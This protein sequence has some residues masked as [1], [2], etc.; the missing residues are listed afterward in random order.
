MPDWVAKANIAHFKKL[1]EAEKDPRKR[2]MIERELAEEEAKLVAIE[3][4]QSK[5]KA[6]KDQSERKKD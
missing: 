6:L 2:A 3:R 1:L 5:A 4:E